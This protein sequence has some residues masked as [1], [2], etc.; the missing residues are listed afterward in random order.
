MIKTVIIAALGTKSD[1]TSTGIESDVFVALTTDADFTT[2]DVTFEACYTQ[3]GTF[4][5]VKIQAGTAY[6]LT[7]VAASTHTALDSA[8]FLGAKWVKVVT[9]AQVSDTVISL[10]SKQVK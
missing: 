2:S 9:T 4:L 7:G 6:T 5:P 10:I 3:D 1:A 8:M